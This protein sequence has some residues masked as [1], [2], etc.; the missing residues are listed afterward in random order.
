MRERR[1]PSCDSQ[2]EQERKLRGRGEVLA[3]DDGLRV[4]LVR[5]W[6]GSRQELI[7]RDADFV[8]DALAAHPIFAEAQPVEARLLRATVVSA[9]TAA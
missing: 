3:S 1:G 2:P 4:W 7:E 6:P 5:R 8:R 9:A